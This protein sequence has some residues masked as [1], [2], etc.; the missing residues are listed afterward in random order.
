MVDSMDTF[1]VFQVNC[2]SEGRTLMWVPSHRGIRGNGRIDA[3][4]TWT[5]RLPLIHSRILPIKSDLTLFIGH[6]ITKR[7]V[8]QH[9]GTIK[10]SLVEAIKRSTLQ[11]WARSLKF[12]TRVQVT[13]R[14]H[15]A[16]GCVAYSRGTPPTGVNNP[17]ICFWL[18]SRWDW[19]L[20]K[21]V[22]GKSCTAYNSL[23]N[24]VQYVSLRSSFRL[25]K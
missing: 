25:E 22:S 20:V 3:V 11:N 6:K 9:I 14:W 10:N 7:C 19:L 24:V 8:G 23:Q 16:W 15:I 1:V 21:K 5:A 13:V 18:L 17:Q 2:P 12:C 4:A